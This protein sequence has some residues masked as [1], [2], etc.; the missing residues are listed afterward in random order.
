MNSDNPNQASKLEGQIRH[1]RAHLATRDDFLE[2][3]TL[4]CADFNNNSCQWENATLERYLQAMHAWLADCG[5]YYAKQ[6]VHVDLDNP[7]WQVLADIL[8]AARVYE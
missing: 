3:L 1:A 8:L 6:D 2:L 5:G 7:S 4:L